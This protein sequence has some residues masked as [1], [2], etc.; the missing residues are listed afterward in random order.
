MVKIVAKNA[1]ISAVL[2]KNKEFQKI[3]EKSI[4]ISASLFRS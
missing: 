4:E 2:E 3:H 1:N